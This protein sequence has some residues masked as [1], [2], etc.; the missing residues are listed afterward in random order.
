MAVEEPDVDGQD[1]GEEHGLVGDH[2]GQGHAETGPDQEAGGTNAMAAIQKA[3][4]GTSVSSELPF[5]TNAGTAMNSRA[6]QT[7]AR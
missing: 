3:R 6:A 7:G 2:R 5:T 4:N 1:R